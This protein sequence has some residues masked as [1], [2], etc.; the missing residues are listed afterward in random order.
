MRLV[1]DLNTTSALLLAVVE[2]K[3]PSAFCFASSEPQTHQL[4]PWRGRWVIDVCWIVSSV[5]AVT[6]ETH[7]AYLFVHEEG[8]S[9]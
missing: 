9:R 5:H 3:R 7:K 4:S 6:Y 1:V 8:S 2:R